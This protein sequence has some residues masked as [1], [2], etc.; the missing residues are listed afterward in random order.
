MSGTVEGVFH[1][2]N[3]VSDMQ[4]AVRFYRD[5]LGLTVTFDDYHDPAAISQLFGYDEPRLH[6]V[7][8]SCPDGSEIELVEFERPRG[9]SSV[10]REAADAGL[11]SVNLRVSDIGSIV[12][13]LREAGYPPRS[14]L[15]EQTLPDGGTITV[16][17]CRGP[18]DVTLILVE[19]PEGR[20]SLGEAGGV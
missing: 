12:D 11:L 18:D 3:S 17:V 6:A 8:V 13:R 9:R 19:L 5:L 4:E 2:V 14:D 1:A 7:V 15:V 16:A 10:T 20:A